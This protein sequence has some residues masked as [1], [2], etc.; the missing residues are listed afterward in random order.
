MF[1][2]SRQSGGH[3]R[4]IFPCIGQFTDHDYEFVT[5]KTRNGIR[6]T[7]TIHQSAGSLD[8]KQITDFAWPLASF[9]GLKLSRSRKNTAPKCWLRVLAAMARCSR[10]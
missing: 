7:N 5:T 4:L 6:G 8:Q 10:S 9:R 1:E 3:W 2:F